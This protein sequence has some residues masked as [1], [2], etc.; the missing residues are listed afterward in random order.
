MNPMRPSPYHILVVV[1]L[2]LTTA[3]SQPAADPAPAPAPIATVAEDTAA[4]SRQRAFAVLER[5]FEALG[6]LQT[7]RRVGSIDVTLNTSGPTGWQQSRRWDD[8][9]SRN[10]GVLHYVLDGQRTRGHIE[11]TSNS[12]GPI[13]FVFRTVVDTSGGGRVD[14]MR[15]RNGDWLIPIAKPAARSALSTLE[16]LLPHLAVRQASEQPTLRDGGE[17]DRDGRKV[18]VLQWRHAHSPP[19]EMEIDQSTSLPVGITGDNA[20]T[21]TEYADYRAVEGIQVPHT[22]RVRSGGRIV[23]EQVIANV[24]VTPTLDDSTFTLPPGYVPAPTPGPARATLVATNVYRL[25]DMPGGY[26]SSFVVRDTD[27]VVFEGAH[28][29]AFADTAMRLIAGVAPGKPVSH[30]MV[31]HHHNDHVGGLGPYVARGATI[32]VGAGLEEAVRRQLPDSLRASVQF[33]PV[34]HAQVIGSGASRIVAYP[35]PNGHADFNTAYYLPATR[36]LFQGDLFF[37]P[38][39]GPVPTAFSVTESLA[40]VVNAAR[41][42]VDH[43]VGV[44][45]RSGTWA[46]VV[47]SLTKRQRDPNALR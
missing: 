24:D 4:A 5:T 9:T 43:V 25:D 8:S 18:R 46:D 47:E 16:R 31:S 11:T 3:C 30:V 37:L 34:T 27:V 45:G 10:T 39:V 33:M 22:R 15:W 7:I 23:S 35:V 19:I 40:S 20:G 38:E 17:R 1:C 29:P 14:M 28:S 26:H 13:R 21:W 2:V 36:V 41:L 32:I 6:G 44:H 12:P 42:R